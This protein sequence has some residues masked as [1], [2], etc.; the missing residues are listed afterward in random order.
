M[1]KVTI[2][3]GIEQKV[4]DVAVGTYISELIHQSSFPFEQPCAGRGTCG[5]CKVIHDQGLSVPD[6]I[7][8]SLL[9]S[10]E[11]ALGTRLACRARVNADSEILLAPIV[12][13][14]NKSFKASDSYKVDRDAVL[15]IAVDLGTTTVAAYL[16]RMDHREVCA[17]AA[18]LNQQ[19]AYG[20]DVISRMQATLERPEDAKRLQ[21]LALASI[22]QAVDALKLSRNIMDRVANV[23]IVCNPV[24][25]HLLAGYALKSL[26]YYPFNPLSLES[27]LDISKLFEGIFPKQTMVS[28]P[29]L[30]GGFVGSDALACLGYF[31]F[32]DPGEPIA[33]VDLGTNGEVMVTDGKKILTTSTA[34]G[35]AFEGVNIRCGSR[36]V[37]GAITEVNY[38][39]PDLEIKTIADQP[40]VGLTG[41]GL[42]S[43]VQTFR[44]LG[45]I[46]ASG[47]I[48]EKSEYYPVF[49]ERDDSGKII[50]ID[51]SRE[52]FLT[53][54]DI[55]EL[56]KAKGAIRAAL[57]ILIEQLNLEG[58]DLKR[59]ILTGSFGGQIRIKDILGLGL[60]P[61]VAEEVIEPIA[62]GAGLGAAM[63]LS[64]RGFTL[65]EKLA[66]KATHVSLEQSSDFQM[67]YVNHMRLA[68]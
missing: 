45:L 13:Y 60:V 58:K 43:A 25:H 28:L 64:P 48:N 22:N 59:M 34:A 12:V 42:I 44:E 7:E 4:F 6:D 51:R 23:T 55:R 16:T 66:K 20:A 68:P 17:G 41:S 21:K 35:P 62:N 5:R 31:N 30:I 54:N 38:L 50:H 49:G 24:M 19:S 63:F 32:D 15:G 67:N 37:D 8:T 1:A 36:A 26:A 40:A 3:Y 14:S 18:A 39:D 52:I 2:T 9:T 29:P 33:A 27:N 10:G 57:E 61:N 47:R 11:L 65:A 56:Q 53:Q 46:E